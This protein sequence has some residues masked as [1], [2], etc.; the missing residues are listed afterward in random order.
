MTLSQ[1]S[2]LIPEKKRAMEASLFDRSYD[3]RSDWYVYETVLQDFGI[4]NICN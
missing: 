2:G 1:E 3:V 4:P